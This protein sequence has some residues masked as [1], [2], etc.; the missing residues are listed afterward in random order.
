LTSTSTTR[1]SFCPSNEEALPEVPVS[2]QEDVNR[3]VA[4]AKAA[5]PAWK[6][7]SQDERAAYLDKF[8][9]ALEANKEELTACLGREVGKPPQAA[10]FE[11]MLTQGLV[12]GTAQLRLKDEKVID[13]E[14]VRY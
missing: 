13:D 10:G 11:M 14:D 8:G 7:L 3:A 1:H 12:A 6:K 2:T 4:A 9:A 5:F